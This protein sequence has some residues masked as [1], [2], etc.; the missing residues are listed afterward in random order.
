METGLVTMKNRVNE[1]KGNKLMKTRMGFIGLVLV[2]ASS[3]QGGLV[4]WNTLGSDYEVTHSKV[5]PNGTWV[6]TPSYAAGQFGNGAY[7]ATAES[8][9]DFS[10]PMQNEY[11][12]EWWFKTDWACVDGMANDG[13][14]SHCWFTWE[15]RNYNKMNLET[16]GNSVDRTYFA[17]ADQ[18]TFWGDGGPI[19]NQEA[20]NWEANT[21]H[22]FAVSSD[23]DEIDPT[24]NNVSFYL[25]GI[26]VSTR[27]VNG[28][29]YYSNPGDYTLRL[30]TFFYDNNRPLE[31]MMDNLKVWDYAKTDFS[32]RFNVPD[33]AST[34]LLL[35]MTFIGLTR[36][37]RAKRIVL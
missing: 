9:I 4:L 27:V 17:V 10:L 15:R 13:N 28:L 11:T 29:P 5:G 32:D 14:Y 37:Y 21:L 25:D 12:I 26:L 1:R 24:L 36:C 20:L 8:H 19:P 18:P 33:A 23:R 6:G 30:A 34:A 31:G 35:G 2:F 7:V 22:H 3:V 16:Y